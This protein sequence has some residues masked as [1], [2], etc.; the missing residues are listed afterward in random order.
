MPP[1]RRKYPRSKPDPG[2]KVSAMSASAAASNAPGVRSNVAVKL[3]D[4]CDKGAGLVTTGRLRAGADLV[5]RIFIEGTDDLYAAKA[6]VRWAET[7]SRNG[8]EA[9]VAGI[10]F[11][12]V[13]EIRGSRFRSMASW[14]VGLPTT[15]ADDKRQQKRRLLETSQVRC[16]VAGLFNALGMS[17]NLATGLL[18][19]SEGGCQVMATKKLEAGAKVRLT[20]A[21]QNPTVEINASGEVRWAKCD[22]LSL[23]PKYTTGISFGKLSHDEEGRLMMVLRAMDSA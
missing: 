14:A 2:I 8:K 7:W 22:T 6:I 21:F 18:D 1:E 3:I 20:L 12:Q 10:E 17:P 4:V 19:L 5:V 16:A 15:R 9:D 13:Q 23:E 11:M